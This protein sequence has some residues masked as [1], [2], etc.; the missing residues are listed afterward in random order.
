M[1]KREPLYTVGENVNWYSHCGKQ[2]R[3]FSKTENRTTI[4][5]SN[6]TPGY[7]SEQQQQKK[8]QHWFE[9]IHA[10]QCS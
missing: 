2:Y 1:G 8:H 5:S 7:V 6:S 10:S 4:W 9:K 3:D